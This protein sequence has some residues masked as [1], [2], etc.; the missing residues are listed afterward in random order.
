MRAADGR[1]GKFK[2]RGR[3]KIKIMEEKKKK[4][5]IERKGRGWSKV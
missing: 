1:Q 4:Q 5:S 3:R 2:K